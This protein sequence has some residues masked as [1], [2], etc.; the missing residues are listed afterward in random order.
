MPL[1]KTNLHFHTNDDPQKKI[2]YNFKEGIDEASR[3][4]FEIIALT[5]QE[6]FVWSE[7][8]RLYAEEKNILLVPGIEKSVGKKH[9]LV[10][11]P[12]KEVEKVESF[13]DLERYRKNH[14][15]SLIIAPHPYFPLGFSL[16]KKLEKYIELF[17]AIEL[18]WFYSKLI[19]FNKRGL[20]ISKI[21]NLPFIATSDT[22]VLEFIET[23]YAVLE[24]EEK[25]IPSL[26]KAIK[27][28]KFKNITLPVNFWR[29]MIW[30]MTIKQL[31]LRQIF[32]R[33]N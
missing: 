31:I 9:V 2:R 14:P 25:T 5:C 24:M 10:L 15:E 11:N 16:R 28:K 13:N 7:E 8:Y 12:V 33:K 19:N 1:Y 4:G 30:K 32:D 27:E 21:K 6:K 17:D 20:M 18:S 23:S 22:Q 29:D 3:L 26:F